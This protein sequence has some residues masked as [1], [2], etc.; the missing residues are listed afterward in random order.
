MARITGLEVFDDDLHNARRFIDSS[1]KI[2]PE[3]SAIQR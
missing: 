2:K 3:R 1:D